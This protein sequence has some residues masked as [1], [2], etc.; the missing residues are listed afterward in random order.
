[1]SAVL[2]GR[3][4]QR[5]EVGRPAAQFLAHQGVVEGGVDGGGVENSAKWMGGTSDRVRGS[6]GGR[7]QDQAAGLGDGATGL[8]EACADAVEQVGLDVFDLA[9]P[10]AQRGAAAARCWSGAG[11]PGVGAV[12]SVPTCLSAHRW[13]S[14]ARPVGVGGDMHF[15]VEG[16]RCRCGSGRGSATV[17]PRAQG[18]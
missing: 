11:R 2:D 9:G 4:Q 14:R 12:T 17:S 5:V 6:A 7:P 16:L 15:G 10:R 3:N 8:G 13:A 1:M 18:A